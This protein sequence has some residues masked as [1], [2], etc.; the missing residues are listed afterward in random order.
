MTFKP[1]FNCLLFQFAI[2]SSLCRYFC[3]NEGNSLGPIRWIN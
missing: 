3:I 1:N 2:C